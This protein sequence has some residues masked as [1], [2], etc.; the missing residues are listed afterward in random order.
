MLKSRD[1][2]VLVDCL[3]RLWKRLKE[4][5][6]AGIDRRNRELY[7]FQ[8]FVSSAPGEKYQIERR[9]EKLL[10]YYEHYKHTKKIVG[11]K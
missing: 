8:S 5:A 3:L 1:E 10:E 2:D 6:G 4:E 11:D 9:H 7:T